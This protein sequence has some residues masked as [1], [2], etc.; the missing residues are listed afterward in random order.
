MAGEE[1]CYPLSHVLRK[2]LEAL[3]PG[4]FAR[5]SSWEGRS[6]QQRREEAYNFA[7]EQK[8]SALALSG[9]GIR[10]ACVALGVIQALAEA[11][12]LTRFDYLSTV[13][14]GG[15][16]GSWLSAWLYWNKKKGGTA[17]AEDVL[18][19]LTTR[20][21]NP[22]DEPL[23]IR[24]LRAYSSYLTPKLGL[25]SGDTWTAVT[26]IVRNLI[27]N[28]LILVPAICLV[29][30][31]VKIVAGLL[32]TAVFDTAHIASIPVALALLALAGWSLG[33]KL[34]RLY[35]ANAADQNPNAK[36]EKSSAKNEQSRFVRL[37]V[38][39]AMVAGIC[40]AWLANQ[41]LNPATALGWWLGLTSQSQLWWQALAMAVLGV[42]VFCLLTM[43]LRVI[44][45]GK[46]TFSVS[47]L[48]PARG[49]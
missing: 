6:E 43:V 3:K 35:Q 26:L 15:Y 34:L 40:F 42:I 44:W 5:V 45:R 24:H 16:I 21:H 49:F 2:E 38:L 25:T 13:S 30:L 4:C 10:S 23:P 29:V 22:D 7:G 12:L 27:L 8:L 11:K 18:K 46:F 17:K 9:G 20:Q 48:Q 47:Q 41:R 32:H 14:G 31:S 37:S 36:K 28:W 1:S 39:P 19:A 33:Y